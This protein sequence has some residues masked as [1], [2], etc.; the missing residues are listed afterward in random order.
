MR[1]CSLPHPFIWRHDTQREPSGSGGGQNAWP[2]PK[3]VVLQDVVVGQACG[4]R[5]LMTM[6]QGS[7]TETNAQYV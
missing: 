1:P 2:K 6:G 3:N 4:P 5:R 7:L